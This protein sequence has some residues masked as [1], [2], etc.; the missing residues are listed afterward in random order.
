SG[1]VEDMFLRPDESLK[2]LLGDEEVLTG[3]GVNIRIYF[4]KEISQ[5]S[6][7]TKMARELEIDFSICCGK[8]EKFRGSILGNLV[9]NADEKDRE[10]I[11]GYLKKKSVYCEVI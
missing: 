1:I 10:P 2:K 8:L 3:E 4:P 9:I 5:K 7:I 11:L 6:L